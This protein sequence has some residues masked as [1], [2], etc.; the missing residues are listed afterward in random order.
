MTAASQ[1]G[2]TSHNLIDLV[3]QRDLCAWRRL[4]GIYGPL[5]YGWARRKGLQEADA[6]DVV[7]DVFRVVAQHVFSFRLDRPG[8]TFRGWL[9]TITHNALRN[10]FDRRAK[11]LDA[12][13]GGSSALHQLHQLA[14]QNAPQPDEPETPDTEEDRI[15]VLRLAVDAVRN[16]FEPRTWDAFWKRA[17]E[18]KPAAEVGEEL[19]MTANSVR[20]AKFRVLTR[21]RSTLGE[22]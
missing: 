16:D 8:D 20:Q 4:C 21:L 7:Q 22:L 3:R 19:G 14:D 5:V 9:W 13:V 17:V 10:R 12:P 1:D 18:G 11:R 15:L 6:S 2:T